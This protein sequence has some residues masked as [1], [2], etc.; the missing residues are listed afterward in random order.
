MDNFFNI[1][2]SK[3]LFL[4]IYDNNNYD[5]DLSTEIY[6][7]YEYEPIINKLE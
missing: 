7:K 6:I 3:S 5:I 2:E 4:E 1:T